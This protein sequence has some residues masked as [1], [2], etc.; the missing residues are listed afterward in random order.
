VGFFESLQFTAEV[1][2]EPHARALEWLLAPDDPAV[3][4]LA[5]RDLLGL[6]PHDPHLVLARA[7]AHHCAPIEP[8]LDAMHPEGW[9]ER[10][11]PGYN[12]KYTSSV[13]ALILLAQVG[14]D[15]EYDE[16]IGR[17]CA[18]MLDNALQPGGQFSAGSGPAYTID[19]LQGNLCWALAMLGCDDPR[20]ER[21]LEWLVRSVTGEG[22]APKE[23]KQAARRYY[24]YKCGPGFACGANGGKPCAWGAV[25]VALGMAALLRAGYGATLEQ[26]LITEAR[27]R[28]LHFLL[29]DNLM[30]AP[31]PTADDRP[32]NRAW[33]NPGFPVFYV[34]D[35]LQAVEAICALGGG[36][37]ARLDPF[38]DWL[39][40]RQDRAGRWHLHYGYAGKTWGDFGRKGEPNKWVTLR[41]LRVLQAAGR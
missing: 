6:S 36:G 27:Y 15:V 7:R 25:K 20:L 24:A 37:D 26:G 32:S 16:R 23:Q 38:L 9:W 34:T 18:Y 35:L 10:P 31:W 30:D 41:A 8:I 4:A 28:A 2:Q 13:W 12:P 39:E 21:A 3:R 1:V 19:C 40:S 5:M 11:G 17:A 33:W 14:A 29:V 22:V